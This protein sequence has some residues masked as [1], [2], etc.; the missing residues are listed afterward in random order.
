MSRSLNP[1]LFGPIETP[2]VKVEGAGLSQ[3]HFKKIRDV[4]AQIEILNQKIEKWVQI[5]ESKI[6]NLHSAQKNLGEQMKQ[7][8]EHFA[9]QQAILHSKINE[10]RT[11]DVKTQ[12]MLDR[13]NQL[14]HNFESRVSQIQKVATEQEMKLMSYQATYDEVLREIRSLK[15]RY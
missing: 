1:H 5:L 7:M 15:M 11:A 8:G 10:R 9:Q 12:E 13:H 6:Q 3:A 14:V 4:E 2:V